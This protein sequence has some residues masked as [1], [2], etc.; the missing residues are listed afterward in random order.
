MALTL[1]LGVSNAALHDRG[2]SLVYDDVLDVTWLKDAN[3]IFTSGFFTDPLYAGRYFWYPASN[4]V[5]SL[6][7]GGFDDW[8][9]PTMLSIG[10]WSDPRFSKVQAAANQ[11][12][13]ELMIGNSSELSYMFLVN[14][15][16]MFS[17]VVIGE[18]FWTN[19]EYNVLTG[20]Y[21]FYGAWATSSF[22]GQ[23]GGYTKSAWAYSWAVRDGDVASSNIPE[24]STVMLTGL[25]L[26]GVAIARRKNLGATRRPCLLPS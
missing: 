12:G 3:Y 25:A 15:L 20:P 18:L 24:P 22:N 1:S 13:V 26:A 14:D 7:Y 10:R 11:A 16:D 2:N 9:L 21:P 4:W 17:N 8:R 19:I 5:S 6:V 23:N